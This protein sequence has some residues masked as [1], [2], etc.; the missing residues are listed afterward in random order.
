MRR[1]TPLSVAGLLGLALLVPTS[2]HAAPPT[3]G[4]R[5]AT[6]VGEP[7][8]GVVGTEGP[9]VIVSDGALSV[10]ARGGDDVICVNGETGFPPATPVPVD[11][12]PGNDAIDST[13]PANAVSA[14]LGTG[15][16]SFVGGREDDRVTVT[17]PDP[18]SATPDSLTGGDG[19]DGLFLLTGPGA[20]VIDNAAGRLTSDGQ[21]RATWS[22]MEEFWVG[23]SREQRPLTFVGSDAD[24]LLVD[25]TDAPAPAD[26]DLGQG[27]DTYRTGVA[28]VPGSRIRGGGGRD[29]L[30]VTAVDTELELDLKRHR[31]IVETTP[32]YVSTPDFEDAE[33][34]ARRLLLRGDEGRNRLGFT[35][36][37]AVVKGRG[38]SDTI[39]REYD[40]VF[41]PDLDCRESAR[42]AGGPGK[43]VVT[44]T[45]G[46]DVI[47]GN[48]GNDVLRG[49]NGDD[50]VFGGRGR[51]RADGG[52][53]RDR[54]VAERERRCER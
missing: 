14:T 51:D 3:C 16:D 23:Y 35:A 18:V 33:L 11:A 41:E 9:D 53:G 43:D 5:P 29:L 39:R 34:V 8:S 22:G 30:A 28:P 17:Y 1:T 25:R 40:S 45:R 54:C 24:E 50:K 2:A 20:A 46:A 36:C 44:G 38:G 31:M 12:G 42:I 10:D 7:G 52:A 26:I 19:S 47:A 15:A 27:D 49:G 32:Y 4:G 6:I 48:D 37:D 13:F 21:A